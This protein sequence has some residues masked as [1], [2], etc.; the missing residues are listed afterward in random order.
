MINGGRRPASLLVK[1][2][3]KDSLPLNLPDAS[4]ENRTMGDHKTVRSRRLSERC[5]RT[6][7][8]QTSRLLRHCDSRRS[9]SFILE[10]FVGDICP[11]SFV[12]VP[13]RRNPV[14]PGNAAKPFV[15]C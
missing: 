5:E 12:L 6:E 2:Q 3:K 13:S 7:F 14:P 9:Q 4:D 1:L 10:R 11:N 8:T 15:T